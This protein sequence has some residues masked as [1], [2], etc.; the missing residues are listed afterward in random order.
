LIAK[1]TS[2]T[3]YDLKSKQLLNTYQ[4]DVGDN[5]VIDIEANEFVMVVKTDKNYLYVYDRQT[6]NL[7]YMLTKISVKDKHF[8]VSPYFNVLYFFD[9][10]TSEIVE[11]T[12]GYILVSKGTADTNVVINATSSISTCNF[13]LQI[14]HV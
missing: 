4:L 5:S 2:I 11:I 6:F 8:L 13:T 3:E 10:Q 9:S 12:N 7:Q 1:K 14:N